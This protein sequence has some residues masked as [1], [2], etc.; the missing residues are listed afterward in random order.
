MK[1]RSLALRLAVLVALLG[2]LQAVGVFAFAYLTFERELN[3]QKRLILSGKVDQARLL[4]SE[5]ADEAAIR[6]DAFRLVELVTGHAELHMAI[7]AAGA[8]QP[9]VAFSPEATDSLSRLRGDT[10]GT[11]A[12]LNWY[13]RTS[14]NPMLSMAG[15]GETKD[16]RPYEIVLSIDRT[17][18]S[19]VLRGLLLIALTAAPLALAIVF[20]S[21]LAIVRFGLRPL[22]RLREAASH[23]SASALS[24]RL[25]LA[26]L[27]SEL[28]NLGQAFNSMLERL[29]DGVR[30]L[31]EFSGDLAHEMRTPL[32]TLL[33]RTQVALSKERS[34]DELLEVLENNVEELQRLT[35]LVADMLFLA[36]ADNAQSALEL[37]EVDLAEE[38][39]RVSDFLELLAQER[40]VELAIEG[41]ASVLADRSLVQRAI[42]NLVSNAV[43]HCYART[44]VTIEV[45]SHSDGA[46]LEVVNQGEPIS[47]EHLPRLFD[48][49]YR[50]DDAR[51]RDLG[52]TGLGLAIVQAIIQMHS[53]RVEVASSAKGVT[54]FL[55]FFPSRPQRT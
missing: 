2:L 36:H 35:R 27:P 1:S 22:Q 39:H 42:T 46:T 49:F 52:G 11:D 10:W 32:A 47:P 45:S 34:T 50:I 9:L 25:D 37:K 7:A 28:R 8:P 33:G 5:L 43:R 4:L 3:A 24:E 6:D 20:V 14:G 53:G 21:A 31:S 51:A 54:R 17:D 38:A 18:D 29:D 48:R 44:R 26:G 30:R 23:V 13:A 55:L 40:G 15:V 41:H 12:F 19:R 16:G